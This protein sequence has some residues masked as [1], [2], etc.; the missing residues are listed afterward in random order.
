[1]AP[2]P[3]EWQLWA[4]RF[5]MALKAF[6]KELADNLPKDIEGIPRLIERIKDLAASSE[7]L[8]EDNNALKDQVKTLVSSINN[9]QE[10]NNDLRDRVRLLEQEANQQDQLNARKS[11]EQQKL[12]T[13][14]ERMKEEFYS[15]VSA[16]KTFTDVF[17]TEHKQ[18]KA[19][20]QE[21]KQQSKAEVQ[22][23][24]KQVEALLAR[25]NVA[26]NHAPAGK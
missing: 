5:E 12:E 17:E 18:Y 26:A 23:L 4:T 13:N 6:K 11:Q 19:E 9:L 21:L 1:M 25:E 8:Q 3:E 7:N 22:G 20:M 15:A 24:R 10:E 2:H 16:V 14:H